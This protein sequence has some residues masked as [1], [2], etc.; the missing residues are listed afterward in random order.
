VKL[1]KIGTKTA[2]T[3]MIALSVVWLAAC[4]GAET[5]TDT[6]AEASPKSIAVRIGTMG[7]AV[8]YSPYMIAQAKGWFEEAFRPYG[9]SSV[10]YTSFQALAALNEAIGAG[11]VDIIFEAE[12]PAIIGR[13]V[14]NDLRVTGIS[15]SLTQEILVR[16]DS[17]IRQTQDLRGTRLTVPAG[18]SSHYNVLAILREAGVSDADLEII[19]MNPPDARVAFETGAVEAWAIWPPW[20]EQ[21]VV[22]ETGRVLPDATAQIHS[23]MSIRGSFEDANPEIAE[24]ALEV[25]NRAKEWIRANPE[26]AQQIVAETLK[27]DIEVIRLAWP[28]HDWTAV[29]DSG[30]VLDIQDKADFLYD[31]GLIRNPVDV[32]N[33]LIYGEEEEEPELRKAA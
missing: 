18:T 19:D 15:C 1:E 8:D 4:N 30:V 13:A 20:V 12:P 22:A 32:A 31:N 16:A 21:Q 14:G 26:E 2:I 5:S 3:L 7:D 23:L 9:A 6:P 17:Q 27:L 28:K 10:E 33:D 11:R 29:L 25:L 24:A